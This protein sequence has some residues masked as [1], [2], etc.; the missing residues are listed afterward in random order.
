MDI[1]LQSNSVRQQRKDT[2]GAGPCEPL[3][4]WEG[5]KKKT[6]IRLVG[7]PPVKLC[8]F[9]VTSKKVLYT[10]YTRDR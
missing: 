2:T 1:F 9:Y 7:D 3:L 10:V 5:L 6:R 4:Q 8:L